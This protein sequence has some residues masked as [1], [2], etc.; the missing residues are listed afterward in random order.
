[1]RQTL[2]DIEARHADIKKLEKSIVE[3]HEMFVDMIA[4]KSFANFC[5]NRMHGQDACLEQLSHKNFFHMRRYGDPRG[6]SGKALLLGIRKRVLFER[7][8]VEK[9]R[10][11]SKTFRTNFPNWPESLLLC[12]PPTFAEEVLLNSPLIN[13][14][15]N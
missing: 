4:E 15:S 1:M 8:G 10:K 3:L 13:T 12:K 14:K 6:K 7:F 11:E 9:N 2:A 5:S